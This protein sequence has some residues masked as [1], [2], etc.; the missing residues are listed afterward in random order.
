MANRGELYSTRM[1]GESGR[2][3]YFF[4]I[5]ADRHGAMFMTIAESTKRP[6]GGFIRNEVF[7]YEEDVTRFGSE[8]VDAM[9]QF[10]DIADARK[11]DDH[12]PR[13]SDDD[14][15]HNDDDAP[16]N[17]ASRSDAPRNND[18]ASY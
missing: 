15:S 4:N 16:R 8:L 2:R 18:D 1:D 5:K 10:R 12:A 7:L 14:A 9:Q 17:D 3:C 6:G 13:K 11:S